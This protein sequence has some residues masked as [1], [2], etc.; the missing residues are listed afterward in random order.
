MD[1]EVLRE[2]MVHE[3]FRVSEVQKETRVKKGLLDHK[4]PQAGQL[5]RGAQR[6]HPDRQANLENQ[7]YLEYQDELVNW[8]N[9]ADLGTRGRKEIKGTK[10]QLVLMDY[11]V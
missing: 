1:L 7:E 4:V 11:L 6:V 5:E 3:V 2:L 10:D 9:L 8:E